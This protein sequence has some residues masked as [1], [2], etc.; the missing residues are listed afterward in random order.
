M[1]AGISSSSTS[2]KYHD[3][4][5]DGG[6]LSSRPGLGDIPESCISS[7]LINLDP[8][9]ICEL[10]RVNRAFHRASSADFVWE[11]KLPQNYK[12]LAKKVFGQHNNIIASMTKKD[13]YTK[14]C[15]PN[16]FDADTK[17][18]WLDK[19]SGQICLLMS[20]KS[21]KITGIDDR[22]YWN[23][24]PTQE[25]RF[26]SVAYLQQMWWVE[27][28]GELEFEFPAGSY[29]LFF[30][31]QL[32]KAS[33]RLGRRLCNV[34]QVHGWDIKPVRFQLSTSDGQRS[35]SECYLSGPGEWTLYRVGDF[36]VDRPNEPIK[37]KFSLAQIDCTHTKGG[38]C[39]DGAIIC[40][41]QFMSLATKLHSS[42]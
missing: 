38:L 25:S 33:K 37:L 39:I 22:R 11:S 21:L 24:I 19:C 8:P 13:I 12:F 4:D 14:L 34:D 17:E 40:P 28:V 36:T 3:D 30:R 26:K 29:T 32:G 16:R 5:D 42:S 6:S 27:V 23:Y 7:M 35:Y 1:G 20:S 31:L 10:A 18:V 15:S 2:N 41:T 9:E